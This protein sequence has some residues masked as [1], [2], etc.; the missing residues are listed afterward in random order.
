MLKPIVSLLSIVIGVMIKNL[1]D[2]YERSHHG[3]DGLSKNNHKLIGVA[4]GSP[5]TICSLS[6]RLVVQVLLY[7]F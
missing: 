1:V 7:I 4:L 6:F 3:S 2:S 5:G